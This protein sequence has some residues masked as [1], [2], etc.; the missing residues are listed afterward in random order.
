MEADNHRLGL[1]HYSFE[2]RCGMSPEHIKDRFPNLFRVA[3][4]LARCEHPEKVLNALTVMLT[5]N[6]ALKVEETI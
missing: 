2:R 5:D 4:V 1:T 6:S 3:Q